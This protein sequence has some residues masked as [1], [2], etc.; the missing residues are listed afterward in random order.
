MTIDEMENHIDLRAEIVHEIG[1]GLRI[2]SNAAGV[3]IGMYEPGEKTPGT[4]IADGE[5]ALLTLD[6]RAGERR[7]EKGSLPRLLQ[8]SL[9][10]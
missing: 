2:E 5:T 6:G 1:A 7:V 4:A 3:A 10:K 9:T 8:V